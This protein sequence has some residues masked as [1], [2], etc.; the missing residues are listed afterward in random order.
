MLH[1]FCMK[2]K[3][4]KELYQNF[5]CPECVLMKCDPLHEVVR[6]LQTPY[7]VDNQKRE[8]LIEDQLHKEIKSHDNIELEVRCI[9][10]EEKN[11]EQ[12]WPHSGEL[13]LNQ[14]K[15]LDF[16]PLQQNSSLKKRKDEKFHTKD[17]KAGMNLVLLKF[18][19]RSDPR[20]PRAE[21]TYIAGIYLVRKLT[22]DELI[23]KVSKENR[24]SIEDCKVRIGQ[25]F[26]SSDIEVDKLVY[27]L[28]CVLDM[29]LLK[30]PAK[31]AHCKHPNCFSLENF[32]SVW[33]KNNQRKWNCPIC[34]LKS[35]D[36]VVDT[37]WEKIIADAKK[38]G[39]A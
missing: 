29:Q 4:D 34:K 9:R 13:I 27:P 2:I 23:K 3:N 30:T 7:V 28:T 16:K 37:F 31:G 36:I 38:Q 11:H 33:A 17:I 14:Y 10:L 15:Y 24:R 32:I 25:D 22:P 39:F 1:K 35:Y 20:N 19:P 21:E 8:F 6:V 26:T 12:T 18:V 5:E